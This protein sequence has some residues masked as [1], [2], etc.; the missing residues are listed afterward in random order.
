MCRRIHK[1]RY[2][3][4]ILILTYCRYLRKRRWELK[5]SF[6]F[7]LNPRRAETLKPPGVCFSLAIHIECLREGTSAS[8]PVL[9]ET[10]FFTQHVCHRQKVVVQCRLE[11]TNLP[12]LAI[13]HLTLDRSINK[14][15]HPNSPTSSSVLTFFLAEIRM[16]LFHASSSSNRISWER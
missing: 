6:F 13:L 15:R 8:A 4:S 1:W 5:L 7:F 11:H 14:H 3:L 2:V 10:V 12:V 16:Q 9:C